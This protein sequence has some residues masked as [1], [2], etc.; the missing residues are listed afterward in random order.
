MIFADQRDAV[1]EF[2]IFCGKSICDGPDARQSFAEGIDVVVVA[3]D[4]HGGFIG[5]RFERIDNAFAKGIGHHRGHLGNFKI[6]ALMG[7]NLLLRNSHA[8]RC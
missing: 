2:D 5:P 7:L 8:E 1:A 3:D 4:P 6:L